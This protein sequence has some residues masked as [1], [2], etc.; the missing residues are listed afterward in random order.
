MKKTAT[1]AVGSLAWDRLMGTQPSPFPNSL[2]LIAMQ[3]KSKQVIKNLHRF[4]STQKTHI[5]SKQMN[6]S[7]HM[8]SAI[9]VSMDVCS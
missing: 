1:Y 7:I 9:L 3:S 5:H 4:A 8:D 6:D 2:L